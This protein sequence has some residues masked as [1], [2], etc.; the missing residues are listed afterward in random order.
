MG[1]IVRTF[2]YNDSIIVS[3]ALNADNKEGGKNKLQD[4]MDVE[5]NNNDNNGEDDNGNGEEENNEDD[6]DD[7]NE[8]DD[9]DNNEDDNDDNNENDDD[10]IYGEENVYYDDDGDNVDENEMEEDYDLEV[11]DSIIDDTSSNVIFKFIHLL[12]SM[13]EPPILDTAHEDTIVDSSLDN[14]YMSKINGS[15][16][17]YFK[18][19]TSALLFF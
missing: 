14:D 16:A 2:S 19:A 15:F 11:D 10:D 12:A 7:D 1:P 9:N 6:D 5:S 4:E 13:N 8:D 3:K 18:N 17:P